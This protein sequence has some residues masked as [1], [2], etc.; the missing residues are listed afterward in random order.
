MHTPAKPKSKPARTTEE[1]DAYIALIISGAPPLTPGHL[2]S[3]NLLLRPLGTEMLAP[4]A[5]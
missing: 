3:L 2:G 4:A 1:V 5:S